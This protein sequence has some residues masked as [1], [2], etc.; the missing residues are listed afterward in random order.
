MLHSFSKFV[1]KID[2]KEGGFY[3]ITHLKHST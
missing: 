3:G 2:K 1:S